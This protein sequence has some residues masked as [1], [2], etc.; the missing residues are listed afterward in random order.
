MDLQVIGGCHVIRS[1]LVG[2]QQ[3][4]RTLNASKVEY[5]L[6]QAPA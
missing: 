1:V 6:V 2:K 3:Y 4:L 5:D